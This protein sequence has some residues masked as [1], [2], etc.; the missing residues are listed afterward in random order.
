VKRG[1]LRLLN[2][3]GPVRPKAL[4]TTTSLELASHPNASVVEDFRGVICDLFSGEH[5]LVRMYRGSGANVVRFSYLLSIE[6]LFAL[7]WFITA[8]EK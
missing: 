1:D 5:K 3:I 7:L 4:V 2:R 8:M 6:V